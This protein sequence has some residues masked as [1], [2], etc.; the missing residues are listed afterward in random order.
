MR[1]F[2]PKPV[3][4]L[5]KETSKPVGEIRENKCPNLQDKLGKR[6]VLTSRIPSEK[7]KSKP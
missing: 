3:G 7:E 1:V 2:R 5:R 4:G 6:D